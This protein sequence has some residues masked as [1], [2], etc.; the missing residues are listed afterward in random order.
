M[1]LNF[2]DRRLDRQEA[3]ALEIAPDRVQHVL[4][5]D[6]IERQKLHHARH[7]AGWGQR[8]EILEIMRPGAAKGVID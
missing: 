7:G 3:E 5:R 6:L 1:S 2:H 8:H 4:E